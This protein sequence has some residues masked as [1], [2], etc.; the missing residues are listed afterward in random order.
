MT[1]AKIS[2]TPTSVRAYDDLVVT[3]KSGKPWPS[4]YR[5]SKY[6]VHRTNTG[7]GLSLNHRQVQV[8]GSIPKGLHDALKSVGK[9]DGSGLGSIRVT[10]NRD[11]LTKVKAEHYPAADEALVDKGWIPV[12]LGKLS[13]QIAFDGIN[14]DPDPTAFDPPCVW[15][16]LPFRHG[17]CWSMTIHDGLQWRIKLGQQFSFPST[18]QHSGLEQKYKSFRSNGG[19]LRIN[20][21][22]HVWM[23]MPNKKV[24][25]STH[26]SSVLEEWYQD[27]RDNDRNE[28]LNLIH[29]RLKA[30]GN[31][32]P[33]KGQFPIYLGH[34]SDYDNGNTPT[35]VVT[36][37]NYFALAAK[38]EDN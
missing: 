18:Y 24:R 19:R 37:K 4:V 16:G 2:R 32:N 14:N 15:E 33:K 1:T 13:G 21:H 12:Y 22:G 25:N 5:G 6:S 17:E 35:P 28:I 9:S 23:E 31:G 27:A 26:L 29:R 11:V 8:E 10:A 3:I 36:D 34:I 38:Y 30:T 20:E 7:V